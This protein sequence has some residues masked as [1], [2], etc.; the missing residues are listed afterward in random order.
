MTLPARRRFN[1]LLGAA[2]GAL[3]AAR[4]PIARAA[5]RVVTIAS[6][7]GED[8]PETRVWV[9][10]RAQLEQRLPGRFE[11]RIVQNAALG[12]EKQVAEGIRLGSI[13][14][15]L[16]TMSALSAWVPEAQV[17][18]LPFLFRDREHLRRTLDGRVGQDLR[19]RF[20]AQGFAVLGYI[21]YGARHLLAKAPLATPAEVAGKRIR[22]IQSPLHTELWKAYG[23]R[24]TAIPITEAY[25][26][27]KTGVVDAMDLTKSA[28]AGFR[29]YEVVPW[30]VE[31]GHIWAAGALHLSQGFWKSLADDEKA[32]FAEAGAAGA[33]AFD[34][35]I[36]DDETASMARARAAG[37]QVVAARDLPAWQAGARKVWAQF[38]A[39]LGGLERIE[40]IARG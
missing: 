25:N 3:L 23:A 34:A 11:L 35:M 18:D 15:S 27:L 9:R 6:L 30:L 8:K 24:P 13:Q 36:V 20:A 2:P 16:S 12:G 10:I 37:A 40:A 7:F 31:T 21:D 26:A 22:V 29:L 28:Y 4:A 32:V 19:E 33:R 38:A 39:G 17:F 1:R 5:P 14:G